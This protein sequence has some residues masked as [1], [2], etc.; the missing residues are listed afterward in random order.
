MARYGIAVMFAVL[1]VGLASVSMG[2]VGWCGQIWP[3]SGA[4]YTS[5]DSISVY[6]QV[7]KEGCTDTSGTEPCPDVEAFLY[8]GCKGSGSFT[9]VPMTYNVDVGSNDEFTGVIPA[10]HGCDTVEF[11]VRVMDVTDSVDCYGEDQC[12]NAP[13]F[14]LPI[15]E[16][17]SQD[18]TVRFHMCL[19]SGVETSGDICVSGSHPE[20][21][22]W[23]SGV[24]MA[25]TCPSLDPKL[26]QV[27]V[28]FPAGSNPYVEYKYRK[29]G[30]ETWESF[31]NHS[32]TIDD[33]DSFYDIPWVDGWDFIEPDC[34][35]CVTATE[36][37]EWG[38]IKALYR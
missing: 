3:C 21:T 33:S 11:Y 34:P 27:D 4:S 22:S 18:V 1:V 36:K 23:G 35:G 31:G 14:F 24:P 5:N 6:V 30:C 32:L 17:T 15:T 9:E 7:W 28:L 25:L 19:T 37:T 26:Y 29:D 10:G 13:N 12:A 16:V 20:L 2:A 38:G 8:Y